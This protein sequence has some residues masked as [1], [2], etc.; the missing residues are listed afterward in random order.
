MYYLCLI[1]QSAELY[2]YDK[3]HMAYKSKDIYHLTLYRKNLLTP[4]LKSKMR[5]RKKPI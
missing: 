5:V 3:Y 1:L 4:E 2:N